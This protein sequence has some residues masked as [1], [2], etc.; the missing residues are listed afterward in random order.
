M[1]QKQLVNTC[2]IFLMQSRIN[3]VKQTR[4]DASETG[5]RLRSYPVRSL[6]TYRIKLSTIPC[7]FIVEID[8]E[9][10]KLSFAG[11]ALSLSTRGR[12]TCLRA[13]TYRFINTIVTHCHPDRYQL[14]MTTITPIFQAR[15]SVYIEQPGILGIRTRFSFLDGPIED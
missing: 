1:N 3:T 2:H 12:S 11:Q 14:Y 9:S 7:T 4:R 13:S 8:F 15:A 5:T 10:T 6:L